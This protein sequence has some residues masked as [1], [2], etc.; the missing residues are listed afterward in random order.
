M[1]SSL[2]A[3]TFALSLPYMT[4]KELMELLAPFVGSE[5]LTNK[6][7][8]DLL[9][10]LDLLWRWN[11]K[12]NL[13]AVRDANSIVVRHFAESLFAADHLFRSRTASG[14]L[15][16]VGSGAGFPGLPIK[17]RRPDLS[18]VLVES[19]SRKATFLK[20]VVRA[21]SLD[22]VE[23]YGGR[24]EN[25]NRLADVVTLRAVDRMELVLP[26]AAS[27]VK[28]GAGQE[29]ASGETGSEQTDAGGHLGLLIG[30][31]QATRIRQALPGFAWQ[32]EIPLPLS[33]SSELLIGKRVVR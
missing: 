20:E 32:D 4:E 7:A 11:A 19:Q 1:I 22:G 13:T 24:A 8:R 3:S 27:L 12:V 30:R 29:Q 23:V 2:C 16:D 18:V 21:L 25:L 17:I 15:I 5:G 28:A 14:S 31:A 26:A 9:T 10:Y 33:T 6:E